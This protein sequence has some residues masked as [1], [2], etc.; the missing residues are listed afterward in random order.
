MAGF[1]VAYANEFVPAAQ[2]TYRA[3]FP[4]THL[5]CRDVRTVQPEEVLTALGMARGELDLLDGSPP[6]AGFST[7]GKREAGWGKVK[8]YS[9]T[10]QVV[11]DLF[12]EYVRLLE[13]IQPRTFVAENVSG[14]VKGTAKG[15]FLRILAA[16]KGAGYQVT[17]RV[18]DAQ[19]LGVPQSRQRTIFVGVRNDLERDPVHPTPLPYRY[20]VRDALPWIGKAVR[21]DR[22]AFGGGLECSDIPAPVVLAGSVGTHW[23]EPHRLIAPSRRRAGYS[24]YTVE[25]E[26]DI[27]RYAIGKEWQ[28]LKPGEK[29]EKYLS[30]VKQDADTPSGTICA[31]HGNLSTA[32]VTHPTEC[33]KFTIAELRRICAFPDDFVLTGS[34]AQQWERL[35]RSVP[36]V[37]M[38]HIASAVRDRILREE[39]HGA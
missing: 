4:D 1:R 9:D 35:G 20:S 18:C 38:M 14:L 32:G 22:G 37:M 6:C 25:A 13:G 24:G 31:S 3:N 15:Y 12:F 21:D 8:A 27:S 11:D 39:E 17:C 29:S 33:R 23:V 30:L 19:W 10:K 34:Y 36:P 26:T 16:L 7:A 28:K 5:D 2:E